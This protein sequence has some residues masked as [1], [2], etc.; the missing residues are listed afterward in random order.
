MTSSGSD[1]GA[2]SGQRV[3]TKKDRGTAVKRELIRTRS[4]V[5]FTAGMRK[6]VIARYS[7]AS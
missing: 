1:S 4:R 5:R 3:V 2:T 7:R 6:A